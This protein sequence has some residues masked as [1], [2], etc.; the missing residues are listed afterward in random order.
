MWEREKP[1][2]FKYFCREQLEWNF[3]LLRWIILRDGEHMKIS[4]WDTTKILRRLLGIMWRYQIS[5]WIYKSGVK[6][7]D[8]NLGD[9][10]LIFKSLNN[11]WDH[12]KSKFRWKRG[13]RTGVLSM[14]VLKSHSHRETQKFLREHDNLG[15]KVEKQISLSPPS[16]LNW[17]IPL[18]SLP[19]PSKHGFFDIMY[20]VVPS[21]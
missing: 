20:Y 13:L 15:H 19:H 2:L 5:S 4:V 9:N 12:Q 1:K 10:E 3:H 11:E 14:L 8:I 6:E 21:I 16:G 18:G 17:L 7:R